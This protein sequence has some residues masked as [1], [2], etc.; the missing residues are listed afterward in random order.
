MIT[1]TKHTRGGKTIALT[2]SGSAEIYKE[3]EGLYRINPVQHSAFKKRVR[4][5]EPYKKVEQGVRRTHYDKRQTGV[6]GATGIN[7]DPEGTLTS[8][9]KA[10]TAARQEN[11]LFQ[12]ALQKLIELEKEIGAALVANDAASLSIL[13]EEKGS[14]LKQLKEEKGATAAV[15]TLGGEALKHLL[16]FAALQEANRPL[17][18]AAVRS[19]NRLSRYLS[20]RAETTY[21]RE[22]RSA[23]GKSSALFI[24]SAY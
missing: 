21:S 2:S 23:Q 24:N 9:S 6:I 13:S 22:G 3:E 4:P 17:V 20:E 10:K 18:Y 7:R 15:G 14:L 16:E 1:K 11:A 12:D 19:V 5:D 8:R